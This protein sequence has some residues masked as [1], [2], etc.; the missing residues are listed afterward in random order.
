MSSI[1]DKQGAVAALSP[2]AQAR[3][4]VELAD[5][6][7]R[8]KKNVRQVAPPSVWMLRMILLALVALYFADPFLYALHRAQAIRAYLYIHRY[9]DTRT[10]AGLGRSGLLMPTEQRALDNKRG[11]YRFYF[12]NP[13][14]AQTAAEAACAYVQSAR[15]LR[16]ARVDRLNGVARLRY[17]LFVQFGL[18]PPLEWKALTPKVD[19]SS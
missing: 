7:N 2:N 3:L 10:L 5:Y 6:R 18:T 12:Q 1:F 13:A 9:G 14:E 15:D 16:S 11:D 4:T 8:G 17:F 19:F